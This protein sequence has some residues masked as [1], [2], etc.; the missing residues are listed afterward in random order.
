[1]NL[2]KT[3]YKSGSKNFLRALPVRIILLIVT[4]IVI[5]PIGW[6]VL[7]SFKTNTEI[8]TDPWA[9]PKG[10]EIQ[11]YINAFTEARMADYFM[12]SIVVTVVSTAILMV[13][14]IPAAYVLARYVFKGCK[15]IQNVYMTCI[16]VQGTYLMV[17]LFLQMME[18]NMLDNRFWISVVYAVMS[19]PF[20][21][22][23]L[24]G[25]FGGIPKE[26]DEAAKIDGAS[27]FQI[28]LR[29][30]LPMGKSGIVTAGMLALMS[31][32]NEYPLALILLQSDEKKTLPIGLANL[33]EVQK[34][35]TDWGALFAALTIVLIPT[36]II[37]M[38][39]Y[40]KLTN[41]LSG[42]LK[43]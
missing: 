24:I 31:F 9:W 25:F 43:G 8:L 21:I 14:S 29:V 35:A 5:I 4:L 41:G 26:Y 12:N 17:P 22:F 40:K 32:W 42:G 39:G 15:F 7:M 38:L 6:T 37:Y 33:F 11:N 30:I 16:F 27:S 2:K 13:V 28:M 3:V 34:Y 10:I 19:F 20:T 36:I 23:L 1:M 18:F